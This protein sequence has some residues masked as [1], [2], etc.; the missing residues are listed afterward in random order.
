[1]SDPKN[2][3]LLCEE[4]ALY[5]VRVA[6]ANRL[7]KKLYPAYW[8]EQLKKTEIAPEI[9]HW[10]YACRTLR[11]AASGGSWVY[12]YH[13][14][15]LHEYTCSARGF[16]LQAGYRLQGDGVE[17]LSMMAGIRQ[18]IYVPK[19]IDGQIAYSE[20]AW[21]RERLKDL[22]QSGEKRGQRMQS[23][24]TK[25]PTERMFAFS[26]TAWD[27]IEEMREIPN[28]LVCM[29]VE[30]ASNPHSRYNQLCYHGLEHYTKL[31]ITMTGDLMRWSDARLEV[32]TDVE[33]RK[34]HCIPLGPDSTI[35]DKFPHHISWHAVDGVAPF[36]WM[37]QEKKAKSRT[38]ERSPRGN[39]LR[40]L[41]CGYIIAL[42]DPVGVCREL[43][44]LCEHAH[45]DESLYSESIQY[46]YTIAL[47]LDALMRNGD[48]GQA[49]VQYVRNNEMFLKQTD[50][51]AENM[52]L[53]FEDLISARKI[54]MHSGGA[55]TQLLVEC[56]EDLTPDTSAHCNARE[57]MLAAVLSCLAHRDAGRKLADE[58]FL[59]TE[60]PRNLLWDTICPAAKPRHVAFPEK[61]STTQLVLS[62][63][64]FFLLEDVE[65]QSQRT[66]VLH[67]LLK[68]FHERGIVSMIQVRLSEQQMVWLGIILEKLDGDDEAVPTLKGEYGEPV[69]LNAR[70]LGEIRQGPAFIM[71]PTLVSGETA[72]GVPALDSGAGQ[73]VA[74]VDRL[75][76]EETWYIPRQ[77]PS[78]KKALSQTPQY[79]L[80]IPQALHDAVLRNI[81]GAS[82]EM[83]IA[84]ADL[85]REMV[86]PSLRILV[87]LAAARAVMSVAE[88]GQ[89]RSLAGVAGLVGA[90]TAGAGLLEWLAQVQGKV[91]RAA[92]LGFANKALGSIVGFI[93]MLD[94]SIDAGKALK[95]GNY[96]KAVQEIAMA[97]GSGMAG[98]AS[99][100]KGLY[101][102]AALDSK[103]APL[104]RN[105]ARRVFPRLPWGVAV[106]GGLLMRCITGLFVAAEVYSMFAEASQPLNNWARRC[107]WGNLSNSNPLSLIAQTPVYARENELNGTPLGALQ[108]EELALFRI[109]HTPTMR[110]IGVA[111]D[112][113]TVQ[114]VLPGFEDGKS[115]LWLWWEDTIDPYVNMPRTEKVGS[116]SVQEL[117]VQEGE[118]KL[119]IRLK[120]PSEEPATESAPLK[121]TYYI[122]VKPGFGTIATSWD[123]VITGEVES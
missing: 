76:A 91:S 49:V 82:V 25:Q 55:V 21:G 71:R 24:S 118:R 47:H 120:P 122:G 51:A 26:D 107:V 36:V 66:T 15:M 17:P 70:Q 98:Y 5:P 116:A 2:S 69:Y 86:N 33:Q 123:T 29:G 27:M 10:G 119:E 35:P 59:D 96:A 48:V 75:V 72:L 42:D 87:T 90:F 99:L 37:W 108:Q 34:R 4:T 19:N 12:V 50:I 100:S 106:A 109:L 81:T 95:Q 73:Y 78:K 114:A 113:V 14:G 77:L 68:S 97:V 30:L 38:Y 84:L 53:Y 60:A 41:T 28:G 39:E 105:L 18:A 57:D 63:W 115:L 103:T 1:M 89:W 110:K 62:L 31:K 67:K 93:V 88:S 6:L 13:S 80:Y 45:E 83:P 32:L 121:Y 104:L 117:S 8:P 46:P 9:P 111:Q 20:N 44:A 85:Q 74:C 64:R 23:F 40:A 54:W 94:A 79:D 3:L 7:E 101:E 112:S 102:A 22:L 56:F 11:P 61:T 65:T 16:A 43:A 58:M 52:N 92:K